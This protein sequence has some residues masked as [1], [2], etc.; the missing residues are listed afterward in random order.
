MT[1]AIQMESFVAVGDVFQQIVADLAARRSL[2]GEKREP[3][4]RNQRPTDPSEARHA[5]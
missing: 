5:R 2:G 3:E 1:P 4:S